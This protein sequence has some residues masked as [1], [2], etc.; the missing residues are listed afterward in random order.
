MGIEGA[1]TK[2][3]LPVTWWLIEEEGLMPLLGSVIDGLMRMKRRK[4]G[5]NG[6]DGAMRR[7][8]C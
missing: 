2:R 6:S 3:S 8:G 7:Q 5:L 1:T 4:E